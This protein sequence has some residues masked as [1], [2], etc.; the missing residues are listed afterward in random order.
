MQGDFTLT[1][2]QYVLPKK[3]KKFLPKQKTKHGLIDQWN[4][5]S[6]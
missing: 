5:G 6:S 4:M 3:K 2:A 1:W